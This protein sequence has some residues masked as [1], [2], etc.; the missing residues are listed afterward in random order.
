MTRRSEDVCKR[1]PYNRELFIARD[2]GEQHGA[3]H[4]A[5]FRDAVAPQFIAPRFTVDEFW[6]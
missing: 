6:M 3:W 4:S 2:F 5:F 1:A